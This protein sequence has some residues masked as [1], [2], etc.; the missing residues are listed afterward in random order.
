MNITDTLS[1]KNTISNIWIDSLL[2]FAHSFIDS[3]IQQFLQY[4]YTQS[5]FDNAI[6]KLVMKSFSAT[7]SHTNWCIASTLRTKHL[8]I[9]ITCMGISIHIRICNKRFNISHVFSVLAHRKCTLGDI[10]DINMKL[11]CNSTK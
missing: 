10:C 1:T 7:T 8:C 6:I 4:T 3:S 11:Y 9:L 2:S 5:L